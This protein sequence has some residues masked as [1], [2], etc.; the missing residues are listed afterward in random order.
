MSAPNQAAARRFRWDGESLVPAPVDGA[1]PE[2]IDSWLVADGSWLAPER[3]AERFADAVH[4][5]HGI[6]PAISRAL[7]SAAPPLIPTTGTWFPRVEYSPT[8]GFHLLVRPAPPL[9]S[10]VRLWTTPE[11]DMRLHPTIKGYD[12]PLLNDLREQAYAAGADEPLLLDAQGHI[13]EGASTSILW[14]RDEALCAPPVS[15]SVLTSV[16]RSVLVDLAEAAAI[17][18][19]HEQA[20]PRDLDGLEIWAVNALHGIRPIV[21]WPGTPVLPG[22]ATQASRWR[23]ELQ[24]KRVGNDVAPKRH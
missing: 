23:R 10:T 9:G 7:V 14:W 20:R 15:E 24:E 19:R 12:L 4:R 6:D 1:R 11:P 21:P 8:D 13:L 17:P 3:H 5:L 16:T 2:V 18:V 22:P